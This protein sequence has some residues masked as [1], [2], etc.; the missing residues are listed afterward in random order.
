VVVELDPHPAT[1]STKRAAATNDLNRAL[2]T[3]PLLGL[4]PIIVNLP[5]A[6]VTSIVSPLSG[7]DQSRSACHPQ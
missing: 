1:T 3:T 2:E 5:D 7:S 6:G 4:S